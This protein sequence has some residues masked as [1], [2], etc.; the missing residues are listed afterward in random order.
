VI[1]GL[2]EVATAE[3]PGAVADAQ[4]VVVA[5]PAPG[6]EAF[7]ASM[8]RKLVGALYLYLGDA[9]V[10]A[11]LAQD[12]AVRIVEHWPRVRGMDNPGGWAYR[13]AFNLAR[14]RLRRGLAERRAHAR[15]DQHGEDQASTSTETFDP[16]DAL[17]VRQAVVALP[18]RQRQAVVLRYF[19]DLTV[20]Q[21]ADAMGCRPG[22]VKAHLHQALA[23]LRASGLAIDDDEPTPTEPRTRRS[24]T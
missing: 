18:R 6:P 13:V 24:P 8:H 20:D 10:A 11:E 17:A 19:A 7:C 14:S 21:V 5:V 23:S 4:H 1:D 22:T 3:R 2:D 12:T 9:D 16:A 15:A